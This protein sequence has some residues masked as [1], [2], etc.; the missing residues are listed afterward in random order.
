MKK[1]NILPA[2]L[3]AAA[4][5]ASLAADAQAQTVDYNTGDLVLAFEDPGNAN[6]Y[7]VDLG[8]ASFFLS[9]ASTPGTTNLTADDP[10]YGGSLGNIGADLTNVFGSGWATNSVTLGNNVQWGVFGETGKT[11]SGV[12]GVPVDTVFLTLG[13]TTPGLGSTA[14]TEYSSSVQSGWNTPFIGFTAT[15]SGSETANSDYAS[16]SSATAGDSWSTNDPSYNAFTTGLD[17]E[18]PGSGTDIGPTNSEL[19]LYELVPT[20]KGGSGEG[21]LLGDFTLN[22]SGDLSFTSAAVPEPST[23]A[24]AGL[25]AALLLLFRRKLQKVIPG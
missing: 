10:A 24:S 6:D 16:I 25:G 14:P 11:V 18:Q 3:L 4:A 23:Y 12:T 19:D 5:L 21:E 2:G 13:E 17:I 1:R 9:L 8:S 20:N 22:S 15:V 7:T